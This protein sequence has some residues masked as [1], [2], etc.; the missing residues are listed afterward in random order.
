MSKQL[1]SL[2]KRV[3]HA[4]HE[5][6]EAL[7]RR[8]EVV[9]EILQEKEAQGLPLF[10]SA[11]ET[12]L[13]TKIAHLADEKGIDPVLAERVLKE[14]I[15]HSREVQT[16]RVHRDL[17][18]DLKQVRTVAF[19]GTKG[20]Y[21]WLA[22]RKH[23]GKGVEA[24]GYKTF[25]E[26]VEAL[27]KGH[28]DLA[29]LPIENVLAGSIYEVYDL[30]TESSLHVVGEEYLRVDHCL[31]GLPD[32][33]LEQVQVVFSHPVALQQCRAFIKG[34]PNARYEPYIDSAE[35]VRMVKKEADPKYAA[36][37]SSEAAELYELDVMRE[38]I[39]DHPENYTRFWIVS[40]E[41]VAVDLR[42]PAKT[43]LQLV[44]DHSKGALVAVLY[45][46]AEQEINLTK[47]ES[48]PQ[49]GTP[50]QYQFHLE[51]E[52]NVEENRVKKALE[53]V[54][55]RA[56]LLRVLGCFPSGTLGTTSRAKISNRLNV[57]IESIVPSYVHK[58]QKKDSSRGYW[59]NRDSKQI[60]FGNTHLGKDT[61][62]LIVALKLKTSCEDVDKM[63]QLCHTRG[64]SL[65]MAIPETDSA[66]L[67]L[68][69]FHQ[70]RKVAREHQLSVSCLVNSA[71]QIESLS[72]LVDAFVLSSKQM[73]TVSLLEELGRVSVPVVLKRG[74]SSTLKEFLA[75]AETILKQGNQDVVLCEGGIRTFESTSRTTLD[76]G[77]IL[78]L[79]DKTHLPVIVD[80]SLCVTLPERY[81][82]LLEACRELG[83]NGAILQVDPSQK[84]R[85]N[86]ALDLAHLVKIINTSA[87]G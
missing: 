8:M 23:F 22:C 38:G 18:P 51:M 54:R 75:S 76:L 56:R 68:D 47:L 28:M 65:L 57:P 83:A 10:D 44:T 30:L 70:F 16:R 27:E 85:H 64:N 49:K 12:E 5:L 84:D 34:L 63:A 71:E 32:T 48:R 53:N 72:S 62:V 20:A 52:G 78:E 14:V 87:K 40:R 15:N 7:A 79:K 39:S 80:P 13:L 41:P 60:S 58:V 24:V 37:A 17:N 11:R 19:Q 66:L 69:Q 21:S 67:D 77:S 31:I 81:Q 46:L 1:N 4:D 42:I 82:P 43:S 50:W 35:A 3:D 36:I 86:H 2:R 55:P 26:A 45:A 33:P 25:P 59:K 73:Q 9:E 29:V 6:L 74:V 61:F